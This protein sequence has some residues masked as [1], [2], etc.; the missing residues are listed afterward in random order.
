MEGSMGMGYPVWVKLNLESQ[1]SRFQ[2]QLGTLHPNLSMLGVFPFPQ[3]TELC[4]QM[5][6]GF[7]EKDGGSHD[8]VSSPT[9]A[10]SFF[11]GTWLLLRQEILGKTWPMPGSWAMDWGPD[12]D[13]VLATFIHPWLI[14]T[15]RIEQY[16][17]G[18]LSILPLRALF[19]KEKNI[20]L[21]ETLR[22]WIYQKSNIGKANICLW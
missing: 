13:S 22:I 17:L 11:V 10:G 8:H 16:L 1:I 4:E 15:V 3:W 18:L 12:W 6:T 2:C 9:A 14:L 19:S 21:P 7:L 5:A 20:S